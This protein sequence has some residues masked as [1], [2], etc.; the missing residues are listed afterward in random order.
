MR[1]SSGIVL[2]VAGLL[3]LWLAISEKYQCATLAFNCLAGDDSGS[4]KP[5]ANLPPGFVQPAIPTYPGS[6]PHTRP[7]PEIFKLPGIIVN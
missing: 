5:G 1:G 4:T 2:I 7:L 3:L 6:Y